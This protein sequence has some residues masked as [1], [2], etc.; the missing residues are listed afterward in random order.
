MADVLLPPD[1]LWQLVA[2]TLPTMFR[3]E[4]PDCGGPMALA[5]DV[6]S[7]VLAT[8]SALSGV[9]ERRKLDRIKTNRHAAIRL[10]LSQAKRG[11]D[12][13][14]AWRDW[15]VGAMVDQ[16]CESFSAD[17]ANGRRNQ[18]YDDRYK[19]DPPKAL[20]RALQPVTSPAGLGAVR[21]G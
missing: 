14:I 8:Q 20:S 9:L 15:T 4:A 17:H 12:L 11:S 3:T 7:E 18:T 2:A 21:F 13:E 6:N 16:L 10:G 1:Q 5:G 19:S